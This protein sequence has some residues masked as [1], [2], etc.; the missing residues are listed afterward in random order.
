PFRRPRPRDHPDQGRQG[1]PARLRR[2]DARTLADVILGCLRHPREPGVSGDLCVAAALRGV[3]PRRF[4]SPW[5]PRWEEPSTSAG[6]TNPQ[7]S[8]CRCPRRKEER[9]RRLAFLIAGAGLALVIAAPA[10]VGNSD[11]VFRASLNGYLEVPSISTTS[12]GSF[13]AE[14]K[15]N[16]IVYRLNF[17]DLGTDSLFA[18]IHFAR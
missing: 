16:T 4:H 5:L 10:V 2:P 11:G 6:R 1:D 9:M 7:S 12:R 15:G 13:F 14:V 18:H 17:R 8:D 3:R